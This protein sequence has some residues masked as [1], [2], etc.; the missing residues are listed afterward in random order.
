MAST[1]VTLPRGPETPPE[2]QARQWIERP[3][4]LLDTCA[5]QFGDV[6][7]LQLG[8]LGATVMFSHPE[9]VKTIF[10][11]PSRQ[12]ECQNFNESYRFVMGDHALF[13]QDGERHRQIKRVMAPPLCHEGMEGQA[14]AI[15]AIAQKTVEGWSADRRSLAVR[16]LMHELALR[17]LTNVVFG[18][19]EEAGGLVVHWFKTEVW[20]DQ[21]AW[22]PWTNLSRLQPRLRALIS[23]EL[24]YRRSSR[25]PSRQP[26]LLDYLLAS[27]YEDGQP[28]SEAEMQDQILTLTITA[29]DP[30]AFAMT[31]L[32]AWVARLPAV[33]STLRDELATLGDEPDVLALLQLP[34]LTA[35]CQETL[36]IHPILPTVSGRRLT[37]PMDIQGHHLEA[38]INV[39]PCAYL[40][41]RRQDLYPEPQV[42]RPERFMSR[43]FSPYEYFP[44]GGSNRHC[45]GSTMAPMEMKLVLATI[46]ARGHVV[47]EDAGGAEVR[48]GT[49]VGPPEDLRIG[50]EPK[51]FF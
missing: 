22:K 9:A 23:S 40:V 51:C 46:L 8:A 39:A 36:R 21:R 7:T 45:L 20:R 44:F 5:R 48:Y 35:T 31:W 41:H 6:F 38:G 2:Q 25:E 29:V 28:L 19:R 26:D 47:L 50:F 30:V 4:E 33:Q 10:S 12:F 27:R 3:L 17:V 42:F 18:A 43:R 37:A 49:L 24:E 32:L 13:L 16:P 34:Y 14:R 1:V 11:A 15:R